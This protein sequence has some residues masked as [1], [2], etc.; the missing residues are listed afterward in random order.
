MTISDIQRIETIAAVFLGWLA[1]KPRSI[2]SAASEGLRDKTAVINGT[3]AA[4][5]VYPVMN[6][7]LSVGERFYA[8]RQ[9]YPA[10]CG[11]PMSVRTRLI[12]RRRRGLSGEFRP[13][14]KNRSR[15]SPA[16][17]RAPRA[18]QFS[19]VACAR[20]QE[21]EGPP[22]GAPRHRRERRA[23]RGGQGLWPQTDEFGVEIAATFDRDKLEL[24]DGLR[25]EPSRPEL[26]IRT[27][28]PL[29]H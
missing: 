1:A 29:Q 16:S 18:D 20:P 2:S 13:S 15:S 7:T 22:V 26:E 14:C 23:S 5:D 11:T 28:R 6:R 10:M 4:F 19:L 17:A 25:G 12:P 9:L 21:A 24:P 27:A 3:A 8:M